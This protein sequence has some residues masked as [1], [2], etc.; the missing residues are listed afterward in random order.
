MSLYLAAYDVAV[1]NRRKQ[2]ATFL[3]RYGP[4]LQD[5]VFE[6]RLGPDDLVDVRR[7]IGPLLERTD[8]FDI[9]PIDERATHRRYR[10]MRP[11]EAPQ[12]VL[13]L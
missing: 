10:W 13:L 1:D 5:S 7:Y 12:P 6:L 4:R 3:R 11:L 9:V 8:A 2:V